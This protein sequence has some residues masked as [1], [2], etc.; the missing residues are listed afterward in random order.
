MQHCICEIPIWLR[1][2]SWWRSSGLLCLLHFEPPLLNG[3]SRGSFLSICCAGCT[4][5]LA[6]D[7]TLAL[8]FLSTL[9]FFFSAFFFLYSRTLSLN[10]QFCFFLTLSSK[11][12]LQGS[13]TVSK[14]WRTSAYLLLLSRGCL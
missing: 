2:N 11:L 7:L 14:Q 9:L 8:S 5:S 3:L 4:I 13:V 12:I 10:F 6:L 1:P